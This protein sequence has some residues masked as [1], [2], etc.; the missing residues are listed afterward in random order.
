[1][2]YEGVDSEKRRFLT[3]AAVVAGAV[4]TGLMTVP[5][6]ASMR[7]SARAEALGGPVNVDIGKV[8]AGQLIRVLWRAKPVWILRRTPQALES[9]SNDV[10]AL[11][12]PDSKQS[13]QPTA[14]QNAYRALK[15][16]I[17]VALGVCTHLGCVPL[18]RPDVAPADL[19]AEWQGGFFCPCH[20]SRFDL[21]G[22]VFKGV[23]APANLEIPPYYFASDS[24][25]IVGALSAEG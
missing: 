11:L 19:G 21:A 14:A 22:R 2:T 15:P 4:G 7:P 20:G 25:L 1:M 18:Y 9:L 13:E 23:P 8:E 5:F 17:F 10:G 12:D 24:Q 16:E 3:Q 6:V